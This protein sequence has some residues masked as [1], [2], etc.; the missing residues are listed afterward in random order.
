MG[1]FLT[2]YKWRTAKGGKPSQA[3]TAAADGALRSKNAAGAPERASPHVA[4]T[5]A[6]E[7][8]CGKNASKLRREQVLTVPRAGAGGG[9]VART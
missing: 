7:P 4:P 8:Q 5:Q 6:A 1:S 3:L 9:G 2:T